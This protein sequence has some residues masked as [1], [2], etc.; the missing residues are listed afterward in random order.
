MLNLNVTK[1]DPAK[2][3]HG[4]CWEI[5]VGPDGILTA[6][7]IPG[8]HP[9]KGWVRVA[10]PRSQYVR[11]LEDAR[12]PYIDELREGRLTVKQEAAI[13]GTA[14]VRGGILTGWGNILIGSDRLEYSEENALLILTNPAWANFRGLI[15][16]IAENRKALLDQQDENAV[17]NSQPDSGSYSRR[18]TQVGE[19]NSSNGS[20][21]AGSE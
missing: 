21:N 9:T 13:D 18:P 4:Q 2:L 3:E 17:G 5:F 6:H 15:S 1:L 7:P 14:L 12:R 8:P 20:P 11:A 10:P 16:A 19:E